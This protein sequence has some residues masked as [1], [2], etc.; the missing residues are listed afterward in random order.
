MIPWS[1]GWNATVLL[2]QGRPAQG[3]LSQP[4]PYEPNSC[5]QEAGLYGHSVKTCRYLLA[6]VRT[7]PSSSRRFYWL[8]S[9]LGGTGRA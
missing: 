2:L 6:T 4:R 7:I 3:P 8:R 1:M 9:L 5:L